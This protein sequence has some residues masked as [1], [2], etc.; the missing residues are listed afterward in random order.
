MRGVFLTKGQWGE[1]RQHVQRTHPEECVGVFECISNHDGTFEVVRI[2]PCRNISRHKNWGG[3][4]S[5]PEMR[6]IKKL[7]RKS[8]KSGFVYGMYHS[9]PMTGKIKLSEIDEA[10]GRSFKISK[11]QIVLGA[12]SPKRIKRAFWEYRNREWF[13]HTISIVKHVKKNG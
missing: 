1:L 10:S 13:E 4:I 9:H 8:K 11:L 6:E 12:K 5:K 3:Q 2:I 7:M